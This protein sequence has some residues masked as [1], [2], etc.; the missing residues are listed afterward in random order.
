MYPYN[1]K[2]Q[3]PP[4]KKGVKIQNVNSCCWGVLSDWY[5]SPVSRFPECGEKLI[6]EDGLQSWTAYWNWELRCKARRLCRGRRWLNLPP[7]GKRRESALCLR[8]FFLLWGNSPLTCF[9][10]P[11]TLLCQRQ[12]RISQVV[13]YE[14]IM[15]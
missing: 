3:E 6:A 10:S 9:V 7:C 2:F 12:R 1:I 13:P 14:F 8:R 11:E 4:P 5:A 15:T